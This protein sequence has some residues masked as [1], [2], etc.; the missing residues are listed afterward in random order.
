MTRIAK[1]PKNKQAEAIFTLDEHLK[2]PRRAREEPMAVY[3]KRRNEEIAKSQ[4]RTPVLPGFT[5]ARPG[6]PPQAGGA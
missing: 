6:R 1:L 4:R 3:A 5:G 2:R